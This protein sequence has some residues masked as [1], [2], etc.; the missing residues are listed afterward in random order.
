MKDVARLAR[1]ST[2]TVSRVLINLRH[3]RREREP[4]AAR[5][6]GGRATELLTEPCGAHSLRV[7]RGATTIGIIVPD[8][9]NPFFT[10]VM[11][12]ANSVL[13][14]A[15]YTMIV[16][17]LDENPAREQGPLEHDLRGVSGVAGV[18]FYIRQ[19]RKPPTTGHCRIA[20]SHWWQVSR[21]PHDLNVDFVGVTNEEG[22]KEAVEHLIAL[23][24]RRIAFI[25]G[26]AQVSSTK[27]P[28]LAGYRRAMAG[29][30][31]GCGVRFDLVRRSEA[32]GRI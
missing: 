18:I 14:E 20:A 12:G 24:H 3:G 30:V 6:A 22:S 7:R 11:C 10:S 27:G 26:A 15:D 16:A 28:K 1:V 31:F 13:E 17:N 32:V 2:A 9:E 5:E 21:R 25:G 29:A 4:R 8:I 19:S 23:G